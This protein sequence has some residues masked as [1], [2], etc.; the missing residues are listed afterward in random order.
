MLPTGDQFTLGDVTFTVRKLLAR[1]GRDV[2]EIVRTGVKDALDATVDDTADASAVGLRLVACLPIDARQQIESMLFK[3][4]W[5]TSPNVPTPTRL[6]GMEDTAFA[7]LEP[8]H[9]YLVLA[10]AFVRN[11]RESLAVFQSLLPQAT[12]G[13]SPPEPATSTPSSPTPSTPGS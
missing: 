11:F 3:Q 2:L 12:P 6:A 10:K 4:V 7:S 9:I 13:S 8:A 1:E 5:F